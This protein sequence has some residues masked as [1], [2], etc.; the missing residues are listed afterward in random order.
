MVSPGRSVQLKLLAEINADSVMQ[1]HDKLSTLLKNYFGVTLETIEVSFKG[2]NWGVADFHGKTFPY[3]ST[4]PSKV[5][6]RV[7]RRRPCIHGFWEDCL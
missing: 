1:D 6:T 2:W 4:R 7:S 3:K 5:L